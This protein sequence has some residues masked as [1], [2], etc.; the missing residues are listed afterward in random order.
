M[1]VIVYNLLA[2][3][4]ATWAVLF[5]WHNLRR[6][7]DGCSHS[8]LSGRRTTSEVWPFDEFNGEEPA[9]FGALFAFVFDW[10]QRMFVIFHPISLAILIVWAVI[11][12]IEWLLKRPLPWKRP[13]IAKAAPVTRLCAACSVPGT[14]L[15]VMDPREPYTCEH[16]RGDG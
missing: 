8:L 13:V 7:R 3:Y 1:S 14:T 16:L 15:R 2:G 6:D 9:T 11:S 12:G 4:V 10:A 5:W